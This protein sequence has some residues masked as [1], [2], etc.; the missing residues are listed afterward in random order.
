MESSNFVSVPIN[1]VFWHNKEKRPGLIAGTVVSNVLCSKKSCLKLWFNDWEVNEYLIRNSYNSS[2]SFYI[3]QTDEKVRFF[4]VTTSEAQLIGHTLSIAIITIA[5][6]DRQRNQKVLL[7][8]FYQQFSF[9]LGYIMTIGD[10]LNLIAPFTI[11]RET[12]SEL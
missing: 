1:G 4:Y 3:I 5:L 10:S 2:T 7:N 8:T 12:C 11:V 9:Y 6:V